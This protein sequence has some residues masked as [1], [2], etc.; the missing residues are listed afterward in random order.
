MRRF[1]YLLP[2]LLFALVAGYFLLSLRDDRDP[3][4]V[5]SALI[6]QRIPVFQLPGLTPEAPGLNSADIVGEV[7]V[8]NVFASW[9][10]PCRAE[11]PMLVGLA[12]TPRVALYGILYKDE[13]AAGAAWL[14][15]LGDPF[16]AVGVDRA[17]RTGIDLGVYG[18]PET[19]VIDREGIIRFR[20]VGPLDQQVIV[21]TLLPLLKRLQE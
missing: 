14:A 8:I 21:E 1:A 11:H 7:A 3:S 6:G 15:E 5:P 4:L 19:Y 2:V 10:L 16:R 17:G 20:Q 12:A 9:C 13:P 18:V